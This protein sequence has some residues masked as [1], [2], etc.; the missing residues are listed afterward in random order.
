MAVVTDAD[1]ERLADLVAERIAPRPI[2]VDTRG[3]ASMLGMSGDVFRRDVAPHV[4]CVRRGAAGKGKGRAVR[5]YV[6][7][8]LEAWATSHATRIADGLTETRER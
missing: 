4:A 2:L 7:R 8:D 5:L 3:A 6:V 1:L